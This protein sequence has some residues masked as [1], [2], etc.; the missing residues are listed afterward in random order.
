[1][2]IQEYIVDF[3]NM[4]FMSNNP[5]VVVEKYL[6]QLITNPETMATSIA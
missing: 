3:C 2:V 5:L 4:T 6:V 1:M